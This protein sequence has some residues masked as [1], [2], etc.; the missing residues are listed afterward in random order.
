MIYL[1]KK[2]L[3]EKL[4]KI[5]NLIIFVSTILV[6][7]E[8]AEVSK[9]EVEEEVEQLEEVEEVEETDRERS[10]YKLMIY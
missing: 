5:L 9:L 4:E 10:G 2:I 3:L 7:E 1:E 6:E 8:V